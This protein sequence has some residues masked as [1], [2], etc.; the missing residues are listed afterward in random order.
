[1]LHIQRLCSICFLYFRIKFQFEKF[2]LDFRYVSC[3]PH[4]NIYCSF[5]IYRK[6]FLDVSIE[7]GVLTVVMT[8]PLDFI[9]IQD[10]SFVTGRSVEP[11]VAV[12]TEI[13]KAIQRHYHMSEPVHDIL[14]QISEGHIEVVPESIEINQNVESTM[15]KG[16][17]PPIIQI[18]NTIIF[19]AVQHRASDIH[20]EPRAKNVVV[21]LSN[22][23]HAARHDGVA[24]MGTGRRDHQ[25]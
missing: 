15:R 9:A 1:M 18:V 25:S 2:F 10:L 5:H 24:E 7:R 20:I 22:R 13:K 6:N 17:A 8:D 23:R 16:S 19:N 4:S 3:S 12:G 14:E 21:P 11:T